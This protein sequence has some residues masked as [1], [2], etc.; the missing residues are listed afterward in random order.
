[1]RI[2]SIARPSTTPA[3]ARVQ[4]SAGASSFI[5]SAS[6]PC[7]P[8]RKHNAA[9]S[10]GGQRVVHVRS[11]ELEGVEVGRVGDELGCSA[12][13]D[14]ASRRRWGR[15]AASISWRS[16]PRLGGRRRAHRRPRDVT[17]A[18]TAQAAGAVGRW[19]RAATSRP[20]WSRRSTRW[21][22]GARRPWSRPCGAWFASFSSMPEPRRRLARRAPACRPTGSGP[23]SSAARPRPG[24]APRA[25]AAVPRPAPASV[26]DHEIGTRP[27]SRPVTNTTVHSR[28]LARWNVTR[29]T[30]GVAPI[31]RSSGAAPGRGVE[32]GRELGDAARRR[33]RP[34]GSRV[35]A[36]AA[37]RGAARIVG[38]GRCAR[39]AGS[40]SSGSRRVV[41]GGEV[42][43]MV[44]ERAPGRV[45]LR[46]AEL[47]EQR[48][49]RCA[50][51]EPL[52]VADA[53]R[54]AA[55]GERGL[56]ARRLRVGAEQHGHAVPR[57][58]GGVVL[59][60][61]VGDRVRL[62]VVVVVRR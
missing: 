36:R 17:R 24:S 50:R 1:M 18:S 9:R 51:R 23:T 11:E 8:K 44:R 33:R 10:C 40:A 41:V 34:R 15:A 19:R 27:R 45:A 31:R 3:S 14:T 35:R 37:R 57:H 38:R 21:S 62:G 54:D 46:L 59:P 4:P 32:P 58:A 28:P 22:R 61:R 7:S 49:H 52:P 43:E 53:E 55:A 39:I 12:H 20:A 25:A 56:E 42:G 13:R 48:A 26:V 30:P 16:L 6:L 5:E 60:A 2:L 29:S 47:V